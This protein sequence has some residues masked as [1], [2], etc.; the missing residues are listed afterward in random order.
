MNSFY[1]HYS[2]KRIRISAFACP[3]LN[4]LFIQLDKLYSNSDECERPA[5]SEI[6]NSDFQYSDSIAAKQK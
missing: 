3:H 4:V 6:Y 5:I 2:L 1:W